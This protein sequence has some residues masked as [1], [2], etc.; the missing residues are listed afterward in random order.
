MNSDTH[1]WIL[2]LASFAIFAFPGRTFFM[3]RAMFATGRKRSCSRASSAIPSSPPSSPPKCISSPSSSSILKSLLSTKD[4][5]KEWTTD[6]YNIQ[7][8]P[9]LSVFGR[10]TMEN[11]FGIWKRS[12]CVFFF[13][14]SRRMVSGK[15][16]RARSPF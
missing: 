13:L 9:L 14:A 2:S 11:L 7:S 12:W 15:E 16:T 1:S 4:I 10:G 6:A 3:I 5:T 8:T